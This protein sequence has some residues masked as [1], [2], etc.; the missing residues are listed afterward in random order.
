MNLEEAL[1]EQKDLLKKLSDP[2]FLLQRE[3][4]LNASKRLSHL[5]IFIELSKQ[6]N[7][8]LDNLKQAEEILSKEKEPE[9]LRL[10]ENDTSA[11]KKEL[12]EIDFK[13]KKFD[14]NDIDNKINGVI[15]EIRPGT[16]GEEAALFAN[17]L[18]N[19]YLKF[20]QNSGWKV[21]IIDINE[22]DL[23]G[24]K[25]ITAEI[26]GKGA[27]ETL[28][29]E[30]GVHRVQRVPETEKSGRV[31]TSTATVAIL[32]KA[33]SVKVEIKPEDIEETFFRSS[34]P[35]GQNVQKVETAVRLIHKPTGLTVTCQSERFQRQN[36]MK[37]MEVLKA[38]LYQL[39]QEKVTGDITK[40]RR[41]QIGHA[42][43]SEKIRTY[44]FAQD[45]VT[46]HRIKTSFHNING[47]L[48]GDLDDL[49][50]ELRNTLENQS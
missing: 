32:P 8:A 35:G 4:C 10:A 15:L 17:N 7:A 36:R 47:I 5:N 1:Q 22:T 33:E 14:S 49:I 2:E 18:Y 9:L 48:N 13:I 3:E 45:R 30:A 23:K 38:K 31:H 39:E 6:K 50:Q 16:G 29:Y 37:A 21:D 20:S 43:R 44:N 11:I 19:M 46:D 34:G 12:E 24:I 40:T 27:Y 25:E 28:K 42:D 26:T 41:E